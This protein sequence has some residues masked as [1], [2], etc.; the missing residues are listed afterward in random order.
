MINLEELNL[1]LSVRRSD[2]T[3]IDGIQLYDEILIYLT[4]LNKF[5]FS[6]NTH[7]FNMHVTL[8][9]PSNEDIQRSFSGRRYQ[10]V[11]SY[12]HS[13]SMDAEGT[14]HVYSLPY[15]FEY[16]Y[17]LNNCFQGG[18][19]H[20]VRQLMMTDVVS[21]EH[22]LFKLISEDLSFLQFLYVINTHPQRNKQ[23]SSALITFP[24][25]TLLDIKWAHIDY[26]ELFL[27]EK[28]IRVP[29]LLNLCIK[30]ISLAEITNN[31]T[32]N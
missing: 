30:Y 5:T 14:C 12:V 23:H 24:H 32:N 13:K 17:Y 16:F 22:K 2:S 4:Q 31:F 8:E 29:R 21:F 15:Q 26:A 20:K 6:I 7:V 3:Y 10:Q 9:L 27:L 1:Y 18:M 25:L 19:F 11:A 28:N